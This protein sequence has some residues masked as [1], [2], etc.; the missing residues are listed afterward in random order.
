MIRIVIA[1]DHQALIDG[2]ELL[3]K[4]EDN[5]SILGTANDGVDLLEIVE[6]RQPSVVVTDIRMPRMDGIVATSE[7]KK[8]FPHIKVLAFTMFEQIE[9]IKQMLAAGA[10]GYILKNSPLKQV[11]NAIETVA[12]G[13]QYFDPEI[14][15]SAFDVETN[16]N[17]GKLTK[18]QKE[19]LRLIAQG[20]TSREIADLLFIGVQTVDTHRKNMVR[21]LELK[22]RG[23]LLRY[24]LEKKY[25]FN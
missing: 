19:I 7:I 9:A 20:K 12:S 4:Y 10:S 15:L 22:G 18:R 6:K 17:K 11:I 8:K 3:L 14:D 1:E 23:E 21:I 13:E 24:A 16:S 25:E 2:L 5:I